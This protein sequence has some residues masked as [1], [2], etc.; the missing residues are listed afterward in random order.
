MAGVV[1]AVGCAARLGTVAPPP[2]LPAG[3]V[4]ITADQQAFDRDELA[5]AAGREFTLLFENR[6]SAPHNVSL[7]DSDSGQPLFVGEIFGG[8]GWRIYEVPAIPVGRHR[9]RCDVH[10][11][12]SG[13]LVAE[14]T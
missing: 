6:E 1:V 4:V 9:F 11:E 12:M 2:S 3:G 5:A 13:S 8:P 14:S 7:F 10:P